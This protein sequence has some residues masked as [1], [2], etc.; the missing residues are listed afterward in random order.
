MVKIASFIKKIVPSALILGVLKSDAA[1]Q[2]G[3]IS[4]NGGVGKVGSDQEESTENDVAVNY[5]YR[6]LTK[7]TPVLATHTNSH[8]KRTLTKWGYGYFTEVIFK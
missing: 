8:N 7:G 2:Y 5:T 3:K 6:Y 4:F 1:E